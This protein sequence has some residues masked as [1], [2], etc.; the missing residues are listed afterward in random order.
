MSTAEEKRDSAEGG[1]QK[2]HKTGRNQTKNVNQAELTR[3]HRRIGERKGGREEEKGERERTNEVKEKG[4]GSTYDLTGIIQM[5]EG[6]EGG[7]GRKGIVAE[8]KQ[9]EAPD[10]STDSST[11]PV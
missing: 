6:K 5:G 9:H 4:I 7:G 11:G 2:R 8:V 10:S 3:A 1:K